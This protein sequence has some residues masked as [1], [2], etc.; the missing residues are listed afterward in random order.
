[1]CNRGGGAPFRRGS[2]RSRRGTAGSRAALSTHARRSAHARYRLYACARVRPCDR[3]SVCMAVCALS[4][5]ARANLWLCVRAAIRSETAQ[6]RQRNLPCDGGHE[7]AAQ[8]ATEDVAVATVHSRAECN[9]SARAT[10]LAQRT[11]APKHRA[12][13]NADRRP[14]P[15]DRMLPPTAQTAERDLSPEPLRTARNN[16]AEAAVSAA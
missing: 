14:R 8:V 13:A 2:G 6:R 3:V 1:M 4:A 11:A 16:A 7:R 5:C 10:A 12:D 15:I 9:C